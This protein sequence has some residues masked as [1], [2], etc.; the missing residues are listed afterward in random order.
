MILLCVTDSLF[1]VAW[2][3][4]L[5]Q[6]DSD[7]QGFSQHRSGT[8]VNSTPGRCCVLW[9]A[10]SVIRS[11]LMIF[12]CL[13]PVAWHG[14]RK[15]MG[16]GFPC[17]T[18]VSAAMPSPATSAHS[19]MSVFTW[20]LTANFQV[21]LHCSCH[22]RCVWTSLGVGWTVEEFQKMLCQHFNKF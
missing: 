22:R 19:L 8:L 12:F 3:W 14:R 1:P 17:N 20:W 18:L 2:Y 13:F 16:W 9:F 11:N 15:V 4:L 6:K 7:E 5:W 21:R 10:L